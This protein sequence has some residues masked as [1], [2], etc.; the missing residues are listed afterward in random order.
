MPYFWNDPSNLA[1]KQAHRW[2]IH[3]GE[4]S[5]FY[6]AKSVDRPSYNLNTVKGKLLYSHTVNFP[7]RLT[8]NPI[9]VTL[10]D[11]YS[12]DGDYT[13]QYNIHSK[14]TGSGYSDPTRQQLTA[15]F[16][17]TLFN[18]VNNVK[19]IEM[20]RAGGKGDSDPADNLNAEKDTWTLNNP[21]IS[22]VNY[23]TLDYNN[24]EVLAI[25]L[26][27]AYDWAELA[28]F[29]LQAFKKGPGKKMLDDIKA[30]AA[31]EQTSIERQAI[32]NSLAAGDQALAAKIREQY[33]T[34]QALRTEIASQEAIPTIYAENWVKVAKTVL[35]TLK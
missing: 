20:D 13:T 24:T 14:I 35:P 15:I 11:V 21:I 17:E 32:R 8:W 5:V 10:Y 31:A 9:K 22:D 16:K 28:K 18:Q 25:T 12:T 34:E 30:K 2:V 19:L 3:F 33:L 27:I 29:S 7:G 1:P 4:D 23:G 26:T 6:Y